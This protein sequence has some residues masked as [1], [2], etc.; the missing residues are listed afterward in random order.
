MKRSQSFAMVRVLICVS[1]LA[2]AS[3]ATGFDARAQG[4]SLE[5]ATA[6]QK[7]TATKAFEAGMKASKA[8]K[9][10]QALAA[11]KDSYNAVAS[12]NSHLMICRE[13]VELG[14]LEE[15]YA[16]YEKAL[17]EAEAAAAKDKKYEASA[18][19]AKTEMDELKSKL[20]F[21][22][23]NVSGATAGTRVTV[24]GREI[25]QAD[26]GK[27]IAVAPGPTRIEL[28][29]AD[30]KETV[31]EL[32]VAAGSEITVD[33]APGGAEAATT[34]TTAKAEGSAKVST[35]GGGPSMR[36]WAYV[37]G[38]V[39]VAGIATFA[40]FGA[41]N[42]AKHSKLED[43]CKN[44]ACPSNLEDD[45]KAGQRYQTI[46][47]IGLVVGVVGLGTGTVLY[48]MS[49]KKSEKAAA[50]PPKQ[51]PRVDSVSLGYRSLVVTGS[52]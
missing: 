31:K 17:P 4:A 25:A 18:T 33:L 36:T 7:A 40:I 22:K 51:R 41:M 35:S 11:Y 42:N 2:L 13:L 27:P 21:V 24:R 6:E 50:A 1:A 10:E 23:L 14:R 9:H 8:K 19:S 49:N 15:A 12:P 34:P 29:L 32:D 52:F 48:F 30:G 46:A 26:W 43:Q 39:G 20:G 38:G 47:N 16:E 5:N 44:N 3:L 28:V 37:A 45:K